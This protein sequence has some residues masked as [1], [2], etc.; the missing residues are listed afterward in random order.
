VRALYHAALKLT[1]TVALLLAVSCAGTVP[2]EPDSGLTIVAPVLDSPIHDRVP[3]A[4]A[5]PDDPVK[6][7]VLHRINRDRAAEG[8]GTVL[9]DD[10]ASRVADAFCAEQI[11]E[12]TSGHFLTNGIPPYARTSFAGIFGMQYENSVSW[13]TT[14]SSFDESP[15]ALALESHADMLAETPPDDGHRRTILDPHVT[16]VGVGWAI[17]GGSFRM[18]QEFL[19]RHLAWMTLD[20]IPGKPVIL[21]RGAPLTGRRL[22]FVT[23]GWEPPPAR[24]ST[25][26]ASG[27]TSYSY[28]E[29]I[30]AF[31][32]EGNVTLKVAGTVTQDRIRVSGGGG[33]EF[34]FRFAP[35]RPGL[36]TI[37]FYT[38]AQSEP[39]PVQGGAVSVWFDRPPSPAALSPQ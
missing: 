18:A 23:V 3:P 4:D 8:L 19:T 26:E 21:L 25:A 7:A 34:S 17:V 2:D 37:E 36:W 35:D 6:R 32:E 28:P 12:R 24:L 16:H 5:L 38:I 11:V 27:R 14:A 15:I 31:V 39:R 9:W 1:C 20:R 30:Y 13:R 10:A 33:G 29:A 22:K